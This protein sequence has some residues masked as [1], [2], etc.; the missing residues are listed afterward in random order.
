MPAARKGGQAACGGLP[1]R[2]TAR[3]LCGARG[4]LGR[5]GVALAAGAL[6][7]A[8]A[9][10]ARAQFNEDFTI[11]QDR[12]SRENFFDWK[13][14]QPPYARRQA[15]FT[16]ANGLRASVGSLDLKRFYYSEEI[17]LEK[18]L[19]PRFTFQFTQR[20]ESLYRAEPSYQ[21]AEFRYGGTYSLGI[22]GFPDPSK[23]RN[24]AGLSVARGSRTGWQ[25]A[26][27]SRLEQFIQFNEEAEGESRIEPL[28]VLHRLQVQQQAGPLRVV[29]DARYEAPTRLL[30]EDRTEER[31]YTG[32]KGEL[33]L[34]WAFGPR[35]LVAAHA[36]REAEERERLLDE[37]TDAVPEL[38][39]RVN[40]HLWEVFGQVNPGGDDLVEV[41]YLE[42]R[43]HDR[44]EATNREDDFEFRMVSYHAF[45]KWLPAPEAPVQGLFSLQAGREHLFRDIGTKP[46]DARNEN[47]WQVKVGAGLVLYE[48]GS[49]RF[50]FNSTWDPNLVEK[51]WDGGNAQLEMRF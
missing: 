14:Y 47:V 37:P 40:L 42:G 36:I 30:S 17:R 20:N 22:I 5:A 39:Q 1:R 24:R 32:R 27:Y 29:L 16:T 9:E 44:I 19:T 35:A 11:Q 18:A 23:P 2:A 48:Q 41:G 33:W 31:T 12:L 4:V 25:F 38:E 21:E 28:P 43:F 49:H 10:T 34:E 8:A 3:V 6:L 13:A 50:L 51:R 7:L 46:D 45:A 15:W 26:R